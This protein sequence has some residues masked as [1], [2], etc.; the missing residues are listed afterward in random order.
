VI[1]SGFGSKAVLGLTG[2]TYRQLVHW[3][4]TGLI[5][6]SIRR[7]A[8]RGSRRVYSF[9]DLVALRVVARLLE[10]G[11]SLQMVRRAVQYLKRHSDRPLSR[12]ALVARGKRILAPTE[13][14]AKMIEATL[15]GQVVIEIPVKP[16]IESL[17]AE[18]TELSSPRAVQ[19]R[20][21]GR[22]YS[23]ILTPDLE[24]GGFTVE[25]PE[26]PGCATQG[27]T[28]ADARRMT[29]DAIQLW[30]DT[31]AEPLVGSLPKRRG[32]Y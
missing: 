5:G 16:I 27:D 11:I 14:P 18:V 32:A 8:G 10:A 1:S 26:L 2:I 7:A 30:L 21:G 6:S 25:V 23:A 20:V 19:V 29:R 17:E 28:V 3:D 15:H 31:S 12:F 4:K 13:D 9:E 22:A 24:V